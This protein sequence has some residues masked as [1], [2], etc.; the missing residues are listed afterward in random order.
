MVDPRLDLVLVVAFF[1]GREAGGPGIVGVCL[2]KGVLP[3]SVA[4]LTVSESRPYR[5]VPICEDIGTH[6][7][8]LALYALDRVFAA[9]DLGLYV[10]YHHPAYG[11]IGLFASGGQG[12]DDVH[13]RFSCI[14]FSVA[15][16]HVY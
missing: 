2:H 13:S 5:I 6:I 1:G 8:P 15:F 10:F 9:V 12:T 11:G 4:H 16:V 14:A 3:V 7:D